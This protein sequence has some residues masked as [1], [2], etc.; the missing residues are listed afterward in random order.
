MYP[1]S[2]V[3]STSSSRYTEKNIWI[4]ENSNNSY[5]VQVQVPENK[6]KSVADIGEIP[7]LEECRRPVLGDVATI[8]PD[9]TY[10][11]N[12]NLGAIPVLSVT[13]NLY[14]KDLGT[15]SVDVKGH[16]CTGASAAGADGRADRDDRDADRNAG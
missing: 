2:I 15:A 7:L 14:N 1:R 4:D 12:D 3:A 13:A 11:E 6:M 5:N 10:G 16:C 9:T 8:K